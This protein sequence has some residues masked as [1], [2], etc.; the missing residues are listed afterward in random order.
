MLVLSYFQL[1]FYHPNAFHANLGLFVIY[2]YHLI[3]LQ[4]SI[5]TINILMVLIIIFYILLIPTLIFLALYLLIIYI[6][7]LFMNYLFPKIWIAMIILSTH[8][9][10]CFKKLDDYFFFVLFQHSPSNPLGF[11]F[12]LLPFLFLA[13]SN[14]LNS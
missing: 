7:D 4:R 8:Y 3:F 1:L 5:Y 2:I 6:E 9:H 14:I 10:F 12:S 11:L 13:S